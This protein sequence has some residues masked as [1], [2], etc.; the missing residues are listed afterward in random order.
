MGVL[1]DSQ[2]QLQPRIKMPRCLRRRPFG[3]KWGPQLHRRT[4]VGWGLLFAVTA[5][6]IS[7][8]NLDFFRSLS[9]RSRC[10]PEETGVSDERRFKLELEFVQ[11][12]A[13]PAYLNCAFAKHG[14]GKRG[15]LLAAPHVHFRRPHALVPRPTLALF[16]RLCLLSQGSRSSATLRTRPF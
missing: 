4:I 16:L 6:D 12:L 2:W 8:F 3:A 5:H 7:S 11:C 10:G 14:R 1:S 13:N 9:P 15:R